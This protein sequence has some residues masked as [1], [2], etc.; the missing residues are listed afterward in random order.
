MPQSRDL[1]VAATL[2]QYATKVA[3][4]SIPGGSLS[5]FKIGTFK[6]NR[7]FTDINYMKSSHSVC[8]ICMMSLFLALPAGAKDKEKKDSRSSDGGGEL[9][10]N[11]RTPQ[12]GNEPWAGT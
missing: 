1:T 11:A 10:V 8:V 2:N 12:N 3:T 5:V 6:M 4:R 9:K 7:R